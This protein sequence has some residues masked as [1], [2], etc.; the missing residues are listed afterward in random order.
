MNVVL[1]MIKVFSVLLLVWGLEKGKLVCSDGSACDV[2]Q[3]NPSPECEVIG[4]EYYGG[5]VWVIYLLLSQ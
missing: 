1:G 2:G 4:T 5:G 3:T